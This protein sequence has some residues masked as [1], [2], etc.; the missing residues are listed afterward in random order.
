MLCHDV[1][2]WQLSNLPTPRRDGDESSVHGHVPWRPS[3]LCAALH[4]PHRASGVDREAWV[5]RKCLRPF[6]LVLD[7]RHRMG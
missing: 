6:A 3:R 1:Q 5:A 7:R 2:P 4:S